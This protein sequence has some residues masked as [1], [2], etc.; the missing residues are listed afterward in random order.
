RIEVSVWAFG[1]G[2]QAW[3]IEH[4][5]LM[6]DTARDPV[7]TQLRAMLAETW[8]H[9]CGA[10]LPL[11]RFAIDTGYATQAAYTFVRACRDS[12]VMAIKGVARGAAL[13]GTPTAVDVSVGGKKLRR[14]LKLY[15]VTVGIAKQEIYNNL[16]KQAS[17]AEDGVTLTYPPGYIHLPKVD[18][19][20]LQQ[21]C[22]EQLV[23][24]RDRNGYPVREWQKL[25][26]RNEGLDCFDE[27]TEVLTRNG[28]KPFAAVTYGDVL[29]TVNLDTDFIEYQTPQHLIA[30]DY[31]GPMLAVAGTRLNFMVTPNHR[32][33]TY[34]KQFD[35]TI[36]RWRFDTPPQ[37]TLAKDLTIHHTIK[38]NAY[39]RGIAH[40]TVTIPASCK[41]SC[42][43]VIEPEQQVSATM[44][45]RLLG[46]FVAEGTCSIT[47]HQHS[48]RRRVEIAQ[49]KPEGRALI[50]TVLDQLPWTWHWTDTSAVI[51]SKQLYDYLQRECW[52]LQHQ[53]RVPQWIK[54]ADQDVIAAFV[55]A[56]VAGDGWIQ[57]GHRSYATTSRALGDDMA[58]L[59]F[60]LGGTPSITERQFTQWSIGGRSGTDVQL[61][62][63][64]RENN[65][66]R[67]AA[68]DGKDRKFMVNSVPYQGRVYCAT[69]PNGTLVVR[70]AGKMLIA[71]NCV[72][73]SRAA[74][75]AA[76][77]DRFEQR[78]WRELERSLGINDAPDRPPIA[79]MQSD[80][81][82]TGDGGLSTSARPNR[83]RVVKSRWL[84]R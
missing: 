21:L 59:F 64:V 47:A 83:R 8:T 38:I 57:N 31:A 36:M 33:V 73:Y 24:R 50:A 71:G 62:Y 68:L 26:E 46:W 42:R 9:A 82:A 69:V 53:R 14:G 39:W 1:R 37:I 75:S 18:A 7:W 80:N 11:A 72:V 84:H 15:S 20:Y 48:I 27:Q 58:E 77:L 35:R 52:G 67:S 3:L 65:K 16:R 49:T 70:R 17:V 63:H 41:R 23:T 81:E 79:A 74:A 61:Q 55:D 34:R 25:R 12:R 60:K 19:E 43:T 29:A 51:T 32:M 76:G 56:A 22:A 2:K 6:G 13:I 78:H 5:V 10:Q 28:W 45:A 4:R 66:R 30:R 54:D 44:L 40:A